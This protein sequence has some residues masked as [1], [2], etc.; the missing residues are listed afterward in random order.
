MGS[1]YRLIV[2][3]KEHQQGSACL[4]RIDHG[5][6]SLVDRIPQLDD[7]KFTSISI[8]RE[9]IDPDIYREI[10]LA[11]LYRDRLLGIGTGTPDITVC[12]D[13]VDYGSLQIAVHRKED[14][15]AGR[16]DHMDYKK[17]ARDLFRSAVEICYAVE[18]GKH[19]TDQHGNEEGRP[20]ITKDIMRLD[21]SKKFGV[22]LESA[23]LENIKPRGDLEQDKKPFKYKEQR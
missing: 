23:G 9:D 8:L 12:S 20:D 1:V 4:I 17:D 7:I 16:D 15:E 18:Q 11:A 13:P 22:Y 21:H 2:P 14:A 10:R 5:V 6:V 19:G 3:E